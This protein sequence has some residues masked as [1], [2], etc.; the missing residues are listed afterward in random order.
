MMTT[1]EVL[2][3]AVVVLFPLSLIL[4]MI[5]TAARERGRSPRQITFGMV[6]I[7]ACVVGVVGTGVALTT[8]RGGPLFDA[9][10]GSCNRGSLGPVDVLGLLIC[11]G[12][13]VAALRVSKW[14]TGGK[15]AAL[16]PAPLPSDGG[17]RSTEES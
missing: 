16:P 10:A 7:A 2:Q 17:E 4:T 12:C 11:A 1:H 5:S 9:T 3:L 14:L 15:D 8:L 13:L 6:A